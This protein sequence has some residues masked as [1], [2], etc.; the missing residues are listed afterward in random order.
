MKDTA[1]W[2][3]EEIFVLWNLFCRLEQRCRIYEAAYLTARG[4]EDGELHQ[5]KMASSPDREDAIQ[6]G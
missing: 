2:F 3:N 4:V 1:R 5:Q 6:I